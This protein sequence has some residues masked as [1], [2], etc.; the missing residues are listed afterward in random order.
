VRARVRACMCMFIKISLN[1]L[2]WRIERGER[3][4]VFSQI[5]MVNRIKSLTTHLFL[6]ACKPKKMINAATFAIISAKIR[7]DMP[8]RLHL[9][10]II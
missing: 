7:H 2:L 3:L 5:A 8:A 4:K 1:P 10:R 9:H 6:S